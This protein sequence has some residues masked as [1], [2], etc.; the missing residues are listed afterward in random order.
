MK[1]KYA[2]AAA[3]AEYVIMKTANRILLSVSGLSPSTNR[4]DL[5]KEN[6]GYSKTQIKN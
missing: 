4:K 6:L 1:R 5:K 3:E 2:A